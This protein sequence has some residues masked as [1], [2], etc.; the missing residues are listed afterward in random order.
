MMKE[1]K[2]WGYGLN[3]ATGK[4]C[5]MMEEGV[6][7][8]ASV[9]LNALSNSASIASLVLTTECVITEKDQGQTQRGQA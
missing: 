5:D 1:K 4:M 3:A 2:Q 9:V 6:L 7:D 8:S